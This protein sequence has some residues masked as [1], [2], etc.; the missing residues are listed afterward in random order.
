M[1]NHANPPTAGGQMTA[2]IGALLAT[3][4]FSNPPGTVRVLAALCGSAS[5]SAAEA[6]RAIRPES[7][8]STRMVALANAVSA[9]FSH[10]AD[11][12]EAADRLGA[13]RFVAIALA[14]RIAE[15]ID[16]LP[17]PLFDRRAFWGDS[18]SRGCLAR[19][20]AMNGD[21]RLAG[22]AFLAGAL[23]DLGVP[24]L[25]ERYGHAYAAILENCGADHTRLAVHESQALKFNH[26]HVAHRLLERWGLPADLCNA[27]AR[28]H[29]QPPVQRASDSALRLWQIAYFVCGIPLAADDPMLRRTTR[30]DKPIPGAP[31]PLQRLGLC[32]MLENTFAFRGDWAL[33]AEQAAQEFEDIAPLFEPHLPPNLSPRAIFATMEGRLTTA[34]QAPH[35]EPITR[36]QQVPTAR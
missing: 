4:S 20:I 30:S 11:A 19:A 5:L 35:R 25:A 17:M 8:L 24:L 27:I 2:E 16:R 21:R 12:E 31:W 28:H 9:G 23:Q 32:K 36:P 1:L 26:L 34:T 22:R 14:C 7:A 3:A 33:L 18:L 6:A 13:D 15:L 10:A 29:T